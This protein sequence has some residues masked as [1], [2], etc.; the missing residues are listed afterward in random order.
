M[1]DPVA[2]ALWKNM[3][4]LVLFFVDGAS[5]LDLSEPMTF[6]RWTLHVLYEVT[7]LKDT[8]VSPYTIAGFST[9]YRFWIFPTA[10][11]KRAT[12]SL[13]SP[14]ASS[15]GDA[16]D[17]RLE[18]AEDAGSRLFKDPYDPLFQ[19]PSR[20]RISQFLILPPYQGQLL[21]ARLY[22]TI[23]A[24]YRKM[25]HIYEIPVE[26]PNMAFDAMR[27][28]CD[29]IYL[30][31]LPAFEKLSVVSSLPQEKL[32]K[33]AEVPRELILGN[34]ADLTALCHEAKM[35]RR[36]F[37][38]MV[39]LHVL[40][41]IPPTH[42]NRARLTRKDK[43]S[44]EY[45]R[46]YYFWRLA[47]KARIYKQNEDVLDQMKDEPEL[48]NEQLEKSV[49]SQEEEYDERLEALE[50]REDLAS[51]AAEGASDEEEEDGTSNA[52]IVVTSRSRKRARVVEEDEDDDSEDDDESV[53]SK[54]PKI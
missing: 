25:P 22:D 3:Q 36:Q 27:D 44:N 38:R 24:H 40:S 16:T 12:K 48:R 19:A 37:N 34:G 2:L 32:R 23:C 15:N 26:D 45:D 51:G 42:R 47:V 8:S 13:P 41:K 52:D 6:E 33:K 30:R 31:T 7:P 5:P 50:R 35:P 18:K 43:A 4:I 39:E 1:D 29:I 10:E 11:V 53:S 54:R 14:P 46:Q 20:E 49:D 17:D 28:L 9:S 21:G